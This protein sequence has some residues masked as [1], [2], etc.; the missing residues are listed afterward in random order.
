[1]I[2]RALTVGINDYPGSDMDLARCVND[3]KDW[4]AVRQGTLTKKGGPNVG[5]RTTK[6]MTQDGA[7]GRCVT[8]VLLMA[9]LV[10]TLVH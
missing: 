2:K 1:M 10:E 6:D 8:A 5:V 9:E 4:R 7:R 3:A